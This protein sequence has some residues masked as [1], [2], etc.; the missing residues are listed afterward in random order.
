MSVETSKQLEDLG[1]E[2]GEAITD[3]PE[4]QAFEEAKAAVEESDEAQGLIEEYERKREEFMMARQAGEASQADLAELQR[5]QRELHDVP[6]MAEYLEA[7]AELEARLE[8][9]NEAISEPLALDF[10]ESAGGCCQD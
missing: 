5:A 9:V 7:Q 4:Y 8:R 2:L 6:V 3:I 10:G 1:R